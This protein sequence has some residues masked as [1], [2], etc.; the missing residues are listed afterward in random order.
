MLPPPPRVWRQIA[1]PDGPPPTRHAGA[2]R[3]I[4]ARLA[5]LFALPAAP[6]CRSTAVR[7]ASSL[8]R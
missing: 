6:S 3:P 8:D 1:T 7:S 4:H 5:R 2:R